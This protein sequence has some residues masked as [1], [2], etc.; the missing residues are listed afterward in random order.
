MESIP[1]VWIGEREIAIG[2]HCDAGR[3]LT[4]T[5]SRAQ[6]GICVFRENKLRNRQN[7]EFHHGIAISWASNK[8]HRVATSSF[9]G[10]IQAVF[11]GFDMARTLQGLLAEL[12]FGNMGVEIPTYVRKDNAAAVYQ[13][14]SA[15][16]VT[17]GN[18]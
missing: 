11:Y 2:I 7:G 18:G 10:E 1:Q 15:N 5:G 17:N 12:L 13:A 4:K 9:A 3:I 16:A 14:D 6:I 8:S